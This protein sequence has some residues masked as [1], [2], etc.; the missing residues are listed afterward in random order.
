MSKN[1]SRYFSLVTY[2]TDEQIKKVMRK[3]ISSVRAFCFIHHDV[4]EAEPHYHV[5]IRTLNT[6]TTK[7]ISRWFEHLKDDKGEFINTFVEVCND[8]IGMKIYILH[9][10]KQ[11]QLEG[12]HRYEKSDLVDFGYDD[13]CNRKNSADDTYEI[14]S[15]LLMGVNPRQLVKMYGRD[16]LYHISQYYEAVDQTKMFEGLLEARQNV[17][18]DYAN[19]EDVDDV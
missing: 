13:L 10:D 12:K 8:M 18:C 2:A 3:H 6:W 15:K 5:L 16:F 19:W 14:F 7:Q 17:C 4:D 11:S 9:Q 1:N